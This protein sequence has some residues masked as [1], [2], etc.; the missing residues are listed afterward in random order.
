ML[1]QTLLTILAV[2]AFL[3]VLVFSVLLVRKA[4]ESARIHLQH[5]AM[6]VRAIEKQT[7]PLG[8]VLRDVNQSLLHVAELLGLPPA[9]PR[10]SERTVEAV[11]HGA[12]RGVSSG[13]A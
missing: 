6:G 4:L 1:L 7:E 3:T 12:A 9:E 2:W 13:G 11:E 5:I 10:V 8:P